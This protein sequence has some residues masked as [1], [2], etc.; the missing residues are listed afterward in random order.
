MFQRYTVVKFIQASTG[1]QSMP[2]RESLSPIGS[3]VS[4]PLTWSVSF[5]VRPFI[6][7]QTGCKRSR[8]ECK[9]MNRNPTP[10]FNDSILEEM[11][12]TNLS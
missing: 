11:L 3:L 2:L 8:S 7:Y 4:K 1:S 10:D 9:S 6:T 12:I 5:Q